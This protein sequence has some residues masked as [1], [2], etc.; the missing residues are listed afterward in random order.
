MLK[1]EAKRHRI[2]LVGASSVHRSVFDETLMR[3]YR[4]FLD[5]SAYS[6]QN[7]YHGPGQYQGEKLFPVGM[8][9][10]RVLGN[11]QTEVQGESDKWVQWFEQNASEVK[12]FWYLID[13]PGPVQFPWIKERAEWLKSNQGPGRSMPIHLTRDIPRN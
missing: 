11:S 8:Y 3:E 1:F 6:P 7:G 13:E 12:Y 2:E 5:G 9:G 10:S 4:G